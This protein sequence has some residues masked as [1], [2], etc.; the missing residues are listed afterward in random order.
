[1]KAGM[2]TPW[3]AKSLV[4]RGHQLNDAVR[5]CPQGHGKHPGIADIGPDTAVTDAGLNGLDH[6]AEHLIPTQPAGTLV[7]C[8]ASLVVERDWNR[9]QKSK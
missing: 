9:E 2:A 3:R 8:L 6:R 5:K 7:G 4:L 1:M